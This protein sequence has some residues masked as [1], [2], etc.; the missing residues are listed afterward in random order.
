MTE[1]TEWMPVVIWKIF[2]SNPYHMD[3]HRSESQQELA[4]SRFY[5]K[6]P[7]QTQ[8]PQVF[9]KE[10]CLDLQIY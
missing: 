4:D 3:Q 5:N 9:Y 2:Q 1:W 7:V 6:L 10:R 8:P